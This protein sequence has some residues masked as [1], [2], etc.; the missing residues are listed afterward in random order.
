MGVHS[1]E[2][3]ANGVSAAGSRLHQSR[4][5]ANSMSVRKLLKRFLPDS[6][7]VRLSQ[8]RR[9]LESRAA[10]N[11]K[12]D[13]ENVRDQIGQVDGLTY[14]P[15]RV[16]IVPSDQGTL[17]GSR[18]EDAMITATVAEVRKQ[19]PEV[20]ITVMVASQQAEAL[21]RSRG[22]M[23]SWVWTEK[24]FI[25]AV[26]KSLNHSRPDAV[27]VIGADVI[28]G[29]YGEVWGVRLLLV[30]DIAARMGI[31]ASVI[32]FSLN[33]SPRPIIIEVL[34]ALHKGV[35]LCL[36]GQTSLQRLRQWTSAHG[37]LVAD[38]AFLLTVELTPS[39]KPLES[40]AAERRAKGRQIIAFNLHPMLFPE[41]SRGRLTALV[42]EKAKEAL[43][44]V[45][46]R[47]NVAWL[48]L[49]HDFRDAIGDEGCLGSIF[50]DLR[51]QLG[52]DIEFYNHADSASAL[53]AVAGSCRRNSD[54]TNAPCDRWPQP[55]RSSL[56]HY[57]PG[58]V[59][60][61]VS[62]FRIRHGLSFGSVIS[63]RRT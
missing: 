37:M 2:K 9:S 42:V 55:G 27:F 22:L 46:K 54:R 10:V 52:D 50:D 18:G 30:A 41:D 17:F 26:V 47:R 4:D 39:T 7:V 1:S 53:K 48:L 49:P 34:N 62:A 43:V 28:D 61:F 25:E 19:N 29:H 11:L 20:D 13:W 51:P 36:R 16:T 40:W 15:R 8:F 63:A 14:P 35:R 60:G 44:E 6:V 58:Q 24:N 57:L 59:R 31:P 5:Q 23:T 33:N 21:A 45:S 56:L 32:G 3:V 38:C 12:R